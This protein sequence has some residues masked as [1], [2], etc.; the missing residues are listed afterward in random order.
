MQKE[1]RLS[2]IL[3]LVEARNFVSV[4]AISQEIGVSESTVR[5]DLS[6]LS[7][8]GKLVRYHG[9]ARGIAEEKIALPMYIREAQNAGIKNK[10]AE[11]AANLI[12][13]D[14]V[15]FIDSS[16]SCFYLSKY[17]KHYHNIIVVTNSIALGSYLKSMNFKVYC[18]GGEMLDYASAT[19]GPIAIDA[20]SNFCIDVCFFS[21]YGINENGVIVDPAEA[22]TQLRRAVIENSSSSVFL[23]DNHKFGRNSSYVLSPL[24]NIDYMVTNGTV[25]REY[26]SMIRNEIISI[27]E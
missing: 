27:K 25:P 18:L 21:S 22:E 1:E 13:E 20:I 8:Q 9:G 6:I 17:L 2:N 15:I 19:A 12:C 24:S 16:S 14:S 11:T 10:I 23:C 4:E 3:D 5:R 7:K 26:Y